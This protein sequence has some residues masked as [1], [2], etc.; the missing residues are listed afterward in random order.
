MNAAETITLRAARRKNLP[1]IIGLLADDALGRQRERPDDP[2]PESYLQAFDAIIRDERN[3]I[4]VAAGQD[5]AVLGCLHIAFL[6][7]LSYQ[8]ATRALIEDVRVDTRRR[9][10]GIGRKLLEWAIAEAR[11]RECRLAELLVHETRADARRFYAGLGF[12]ESHIGMR[13]AL[14]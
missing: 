8:G 5:G 11:R 9:G 12:Q 10:H 1:A 14:P 3:L 4:L 7:G 13:L 2:L 6:P